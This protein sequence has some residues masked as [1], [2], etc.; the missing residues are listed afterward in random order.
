[1]SDMALPVAGEV[2]R[3]AALQCQPGYAMHLIPVRDAAVIL[4]P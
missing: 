4:P 1:M 2:H 3:L